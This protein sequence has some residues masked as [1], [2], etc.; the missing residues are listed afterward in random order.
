[1]ERYAN[2]MLPSNE[3][4]SLDEHLVECA[5]CREVLS[6][7]ISQDI[8]LAFSQ[9]QSGELEHPEYSDLEAYVDDSCDATDREIVES[10][11]LICSVCAGD[12]REMQSIRKQAESEKP[13]GKV[14]VP[15]RPFYAT[16]IFRYGAV[17]A[18]A[19]IVVLVLNVTRG[20]VVPRNQAKSTTRQYPEKIVTP[21]PQNEPPLVAM[22]D[23]GATIGIDAKGKLVGA[24]Q[25]PPAY[26]QMALAALTGQKVVIPTLVNDLGGES[27][28]LLGE[29]ENAPTFQLVAPVGIVVESARP[30][31]QWKPLAGAEQYQVRVFDQEF[32]PV[33]T[34]S[35]IANTS[36]SPD[37]DLQRSRIYVWSVVAIKDGQEIEAPAP[38]E[39]EARF[40]VLDSSKLQ[41][42]QSFRKTGSHLLLGLACINAGM[43]P[44]ARHEFEV[45]LAQNPDSPLA[46]NLLASLQ[47]Y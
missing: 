5:E 42:I 9:L 1:M 3:V 36:W 28:A 23:Q 18:A 6:G 21:L 4:I 26:Q 32:H 45:L 43:I 39:P 13:A 17:A 38:P 2:Q 25:F 15:F 41:E 27:R 30:Q 7:Y 34:S 33:I 47:N 29:S 11:L 10:H 24:D 14:V 46:K 44:E 40:Q 20:P 8:D 22:K 37:T 16:R 31:F 19:I 35:M 12:V